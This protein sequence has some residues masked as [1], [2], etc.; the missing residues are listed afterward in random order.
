ML[1]LKSWG[2]Q[3]YFQRNDVNALRLA[4]VKNT[5]IGDETRRGVSGGQRK[6]VNIGL[7]MVPIIP[8][9]HLL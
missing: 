4:H 9:D 1:W 6:R 7:E 5:P 2:I 3:Q 8:I